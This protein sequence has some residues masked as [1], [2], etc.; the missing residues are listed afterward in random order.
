MTAARQ[1]SNTTKAYGGTEITPK[2]QAVAKDIQNLIKKNKKHKSVIY[3]NYIGSGIQEIENELKKGGISSEMYSGAL[4]DKEKKQIITNYNTGKNNTLLLG[5][6]GAE[7]LDLKGTRSIHIVDPAWNKSKI[8]QVIGRGIRFGSHD[9]LPKN[10]R[11]VKVIKY[12]S[13]LP[14]TLFQKILRQKADK[15]S[16]EYLYE[17]S[18]SKQKLLDQFLKVLKKEG[19]KK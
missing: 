13:T 11:N 14:K 17:L 2:I 1:V 6:A 19:V 3:S 8:D 15:G 7:G 12:Q 4:N 5:P 9:A 10:E 16:D 18:A